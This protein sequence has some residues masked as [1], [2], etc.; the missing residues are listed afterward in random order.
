[1]S[2][3]K[4][5]IL[6]LVLIATA[7]AS[8]VVVLTDNS[9]IYSKGHD[10]DG[11]MIRLFTPAGIKLVDPELIL[12]FELVGMKI[13]PPPPLGSD[14][15]LATVLPVPKAPDIREVIREAA[16]RHGISL[17]FVMSI[18]AAESGFDF[19][20]VSSKGAV[21]LMQVMPTTALSLGFDATIPEQNVEA[22]T[23]YLSMLYEKYS[24]FRDGLKR[25]IAAY[26][27][28]PAAVDRYRGVPPYPETR[29][30][31]ARVL[32]LLKTFRKE[33]K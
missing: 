11:A 18:I 31:V 6:F 26:N 25:A 2:F 32:A 27:A 15:L 10:N 23:T 12:R 28:G 29:S 24:R 33:G 3:W 1:M 4:A 8:E 19:D 30:Y 7:V 22:G 21:G 16:L 17:A 9:R 20:A 5:L 14:I 13:P